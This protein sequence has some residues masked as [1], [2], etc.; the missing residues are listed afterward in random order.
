MKHGQLKTVRYPF[1]F[2]DSP[3]EIEIEFGKSVNRRRRKEEHGRQVRAIS[4][5][6]PRAYM[7]SDFGVDDLFFFVVAF[8]L[9]K[10]ANKK[11]DSFTERSKHLPFIYNL[12]RVRIGF[13]R[14]YL[15]L[16]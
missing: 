7:R 12:I 9:L 2:E 15:F 5:T 3:D 11:V 6:P 10:R 16:E 4:P 1:P 14:E 13:F 8:A